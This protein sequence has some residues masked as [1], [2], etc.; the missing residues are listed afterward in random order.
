MCPVIPANKSNQCNCLF[1]NLHRRGLNND[2]HGT[3]SSSRSGDPLDSDEDVF[4]VLRQYTDTWTTKRITYWDRP[5]TPARCN[6]SSVA[7][8]LLTMF[9]NTYF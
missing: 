8:V 4:E 2:F 9:R 3:A 1:L 5:G 7:R 6:L